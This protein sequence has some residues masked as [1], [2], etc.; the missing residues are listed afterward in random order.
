MTSPDPRARAGSLADLLAGQGD[1]T[2]ERWRQA[3]VEVPRH[4][5]VP[6]VAWANPD[7]PAPG[8]PVDRAG[9]ETT[10]WEA[11]YSDASLVTQR[12]DGRSDVLGDGLASSSCSAP[13]AVFAFLESLRVKDH[14]RVLEIGTGTGWTAALLS[15]RIGDQNV[16]TIEIDP[17]LAERAAANLNAAGYAPRLVVGDGA[18]GWPDGAPFDR[19]HVTCAVATI[20]Y[21]WVEQTRPGGLIL[22]PYSP[23]YGYGWLA[24]LVVVGDGTAVGRFPS[25]AGYMLLR[26]QRPARGAAF[27]WVHE[28]DDP[29]ESTTR[30]DPRHLHDDTDA[31]LSIC[32]GVPGVHKRLYYDEETGSGEATFWVL[33]N[34]GHHG[35]WASVDYVPGK[36][37]FLVQQ[38]GPRRLWDEVSEAYLRWLSLGRPARDRF[39]LTVSPEGER[40][41]LDDPIDL[42]GP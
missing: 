35:S 38:H 30:L 4:L 32:A 12:D 37:E 40:V 9:D 15:H 28:S 24:S 1:L 22:T 21:A 26:S 17:V 18:E 36:T 7:G 31:D 29:A 16:T 11:V 27:D 8:Y 3:L 10:W 14:D 20:P 13:G 2:D 19:V 34:A 39:G 6:D 41:W 33:D 23:G 42:V 5:F 25:S